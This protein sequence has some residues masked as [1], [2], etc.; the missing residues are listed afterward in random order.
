MF[1]VAIITLLRIDGLVAGKITVMVGW[2][3]LGATPWRNLTVSIYSGNAGVLAW[4]YRQLLCQSRRSVVFLLG[5][6]WSLLEDW[7]GYSVHSSRRWIFVLQTRICWAFRSAFSEENSQSLRP[8][9]LQSTMLN[10]NRIS[11]VNIQPPDNDN[12]AVYFVILIC[13]Y[14]IDFSGDTWLG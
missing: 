11:W 4:I 14:S 12:L 7:I 5:V 1:I 6:C 8:F 9:S 10:N 13:N 3:G 2:V